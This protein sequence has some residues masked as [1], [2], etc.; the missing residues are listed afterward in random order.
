MARYR[1]KPVEIEAFQLGIDEPHQWWKEAVDTGKAIVDGK[2]AFIETLEG[3]LRANA[4]DYII[5]G[6]A[7]ELYPCKPD[8]F[9]ATYERVEA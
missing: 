1:K 5:R 8:I 4:A 3:V 7:G 2:E 9:E 6:V